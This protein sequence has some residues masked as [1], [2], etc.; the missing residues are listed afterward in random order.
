[1]KQERP[2]KHMDDLINCVYQKDLFLELE[3]RDSP[4]WRNVLKTV[5]RSITKA[6]GSA[7][8]GQALDIFERMMRLEMEYQIH[9]KKL[10]ARPGPRP[11]EPETVEPEP[12]KPNEPEAA[13]QYL[14]T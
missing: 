14:I 8:A 12:E 2:K 13:E 10:K 11:K 4:E 7:D 3:S 1:M 5:R 6:A 9:V